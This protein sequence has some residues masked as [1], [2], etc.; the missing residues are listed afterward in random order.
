MPWR[1]AEALAYQGLP[2]RDRAAVRGAAWRFHRRFC[3]FPWVTVYPADLLYAIQVKRSLGPDDVSGLLI[4]C[5]AFKLQSMSRTAVP[6]S[7][8]LAFLTA[9]LTLQL[10]TAHA[11][12]WKADNTLRPGDTFKDCAD[13]PEMEVI[14]S[15]RFRM[16]DLQGGR[17]HTEKPVHDVHID[18][19]FAVG[20]FEVTQAQWR[21]VMGSVGVLG[22]QSAV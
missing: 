21:A 9:A 8:F 1:Y 18:Y 2:S 13:C 16:G 14:P 7:F 6:T 20:K 10:G 11:G 19:S 4:R 3:N 17:V 5:L 12:R 15:G 22:R